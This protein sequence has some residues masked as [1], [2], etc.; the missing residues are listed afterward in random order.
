MVDYYDTSQVTSFVDGGWEHADKPLSSPAESTTAYPAIL[1]E[2]ITLFVKTGAT[3]SRKLAVR[4]QTA[5]ETY[6]YS[7]SA[8]YAKGVIIRAVT[9]R[10]GTNDLHIEEVEIAKGDFYPPCD[11]V[12]TNT[13]INNKSAE[14]PFV[15][16]RPY[17][18]H[19]ASD[20]QPGWGCCWM[21]K[22]GHK[23]SISTRHWC[24]WPTGETTRT[25]GSADVSA[26]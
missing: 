9:P 3:G 23:Y 6:H 16:V 18:Y 20:S 1:V 19:S 26:Y 10:Y 17:N 5:D 13:Y 7:N 4:M 15:K 11:W 14:S 2:Y 24:T 8:S 21:V 12:Q 25:V 22:D